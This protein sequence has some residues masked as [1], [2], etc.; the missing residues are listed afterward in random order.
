MGLSV[1]ERAVLKATILRLMEAP[2]RADV[3]QQGMA[4]Q[5]V[6]RAINKLTDVRQLANVTARLDILRRCA[7]DDAAQLDELA[8]CRTNFLYWLEY[9]AW[10]YDPRHRGMRMLPF[11][12]YEFQREAAQWLQQLRTDQA[13]GVVEKARDM[14]ATWLMVAFFTWCWLFEDEFT[15]LFCSRKVTLVDSK[16]DPS[17][18]MHKARLIIRALPAWMTPSGYDESKHGL[19]LRIINPANG[20]VLVGEGGNQI[21]RGGRASMVLIDE[22][23]FTAS[24]ENVE[25]AL[26]ETAECKVWLST[27]NNPGDWFSRKR[28]AA[29]ARVLTLRWKLDPRKNTWK[30]FDKAGQEVATGTGDAPDPASIG[31]RLVVWPW[32]EAAKA[33]FTDPAKLAREVDID[34]SASSDRLVFPGAWVRA[35]INL[36]LGDMGTIVEC[37]ADLSGSGADSDVWTMRRGASV[38]FQKV[39]VRPNPTLTARALLMVCESVKASCLHYDAGGGYG[40]ALA[41]EYDPDTNGGKAWP[42]VLHAVNGGSKP[43]RRHFGDKQARELFLNL[44]AEM[45]WTV[46]ERF[47]MAY[48]LYLWRTGDPNGI[49]HD[50]T[51]CISIPDDAELVAQLSS[52]LFVESRS[53][54]VQLESK[55]AMR[56]R[57]VKSPDKAD[58][59][60]YAFA[61]T[62]DPAAVQAA[63]THVMT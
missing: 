41:G 5:L 48:E 46:R 32:Y 36:D 12:P 50:P 22:A 11:V 52:I 26:S 38:P 28:F 19:K 61:P 2:K 17:S 1:A 39:I 16:G 62:P 60:V 6:L 44:R 7:N 45:Y 58:S 13:E 8:R 15:G 37:G 55:E 35:A 24:P 56:E 27:P 30:A 51:E 9:Y 18:I 42:F 49:N 59:L 34:Y 54:K 63:H 3:A 10:T 20:S 43:S 29:G 21:G 40:G 25:A 57:G 14:G 53:G 4:V 23:A 47:R 33:R 31:A